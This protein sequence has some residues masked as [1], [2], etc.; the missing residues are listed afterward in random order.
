MGNGDF[1]GGADV[2]DAEML[3]LVAHH[4]DAGDKI[5]D[6]AE[7]ARFLAGALDIE[8]Q[9]AARLLR[10]EFMHAQR[11]LRNDM[12]EAHVGAVDIVRPEDQHALE[13]F[14]A[15]ID[16]HQLTDQLAAAVGVAR[17]ERIGDRQRGALVGRHL[18][19]C[20]IDFGR[21]CENK[22]ADV[23]FAA[24]V[25]DVDHA[26]HANIEH[27]LGL[28][29]EKFGAVDEGEMVHLV[30]ALRGALDGG[31]IADI[32][33]DE[34][35]IFL[36]FGQTARTAA[37]IVVEHADALAV[38]DQSFDQARADEAAAAGD[39]NFRAAHE[40]PFCLTLLA[41]RSRKAVAKAYRNQR[42]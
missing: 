7:A 26:A 14:A 11:E 17:I 5:V 36:D 10:P 28:A 25:D 1:L 38:L 18:W 3:A 16:R 41:G 6:E 9:V 29:V 30:H 33:A 39:E 19:R 8:L 23:M 40:W 12:L 37:R 31:G 35:D 24:G 4:H 20:L 34:F 21:R 27:K 13:I 42:I 22:L 32:A 2:I 15:V